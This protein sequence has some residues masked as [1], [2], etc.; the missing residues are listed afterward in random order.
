M[1]KQF[2]PM[3]NAQFLLDKF[4]L[5]ADELL[6]LDGEEMLVI[7]GGGAGCGCGCGC[8]CIV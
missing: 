6:I 4:E 3:K 7:E 5:L 8:G 2:V 1:E